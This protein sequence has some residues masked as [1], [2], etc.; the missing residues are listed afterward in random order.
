MESVM[1]RVTT[2]W[3]SADAT[4]GNPLAHHHSP[5]WTTREIP[6]AIVR[7]SRGQEFA[8]ETVM[9]EVHTQAG[10]NHY[11]KRLVQE[12]PEIDLW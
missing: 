3:W 1:Y 6:E 2:L 5:E 10:L 11:V 12:P 8:V 7:W 4:R 9:I